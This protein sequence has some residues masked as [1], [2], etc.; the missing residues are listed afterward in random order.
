MAF[1]KKK[2]VVSSLI[3]VVPD[4]PGSDSG[5]GQRSLLFLDAAAELGPVHVVILSHHIPNDAALQLPQAAS[6]VNWGEGSLKPTGIIRYLPLFTLRGLRLLAP[7]KFYQADPNFRRQLDRLIDQTGA[8]VVLFRYFRTFA[9]TG[10]FKR[11]PLTVMVDID[12]RDDQKYT[13]RLTSTFGERLGGTWAF[14]ASMRK[15][16][17]IMQN[18]LSKASLVWFTASEDAW[19]LPG[20]QTAIL[21]NVARTVPVLTVPL[22]PSQGDS[23]LFVGI[24]SHTPNRDGISWFL[25]HCW[26]ELSRRFPQ[27][28]L[29]IVGRGMLWHEM[30]ARYTHLE[31]VDFVGPVDDLDV[32]YNRARL[33]ICPVREGGGSKIKVIEA[34]AFG[35][36]IVGVPHAFRGFDE[37][38]RDHATEALTPKDFVEACA[39]FL[40][41]DGHAD[42]SGKALAEWQRRNYSYEAAKDRIKADILSTLSVQKR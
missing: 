6:V 19:A 38:I 35:R 34:A 11:D 24:Y 15:L 14:R 16:A 41:D 3:L 4:F 2:P 28:R 13:S 9:A 39:A 33:C 36:P 26:A 8:K 20:T 23:I 40:S 12:D 1:E 31:R 18:R 42:R 7:Q 22:P 10:L 37:G 30:A 5:T 32:E 29:R 27:I 21:P 25:D 17:L